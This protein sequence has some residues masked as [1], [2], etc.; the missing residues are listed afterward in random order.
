MQ[1]GSNKKRQKPA[2]AAS[3]AKYSLIF[4]RN[5]TQRARGSLCPRVSL[6]RFHTF[7]VCLTA[8]DRRGLGGEGVG[9]VGWGV[10]GGDFSTGVEGGRGCGEV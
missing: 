10:G 6:V 7:D 4:G 3:A 9:C 8:C 5:L 2:K 1:T